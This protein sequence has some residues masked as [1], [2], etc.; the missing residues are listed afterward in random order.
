M[1]TN[2]KLSKDYIDIPTSYN[3]K[4]GV[5]FSYSFWLRRGTHTNEKIRNMIIFTKGAP[6]ISPV[7]KEPMKGYI[8]QHDGQQNS[9][10]N[11]IYKEFQ[12]ELKINDQN[13]DSKIQKI[14]NNRLVKCPLVRFGETNDSLRIELNTIKNPHLFI[15]VDS[16]IFSLLKSSKKLSKYNLISFSI[17]DNV[18]FGGIERGIRVDVYIDDAL[19]KTQSFEN[20]ALMTN[21]GPMNLFPSN[22]DTTGDV[23]EIDVDIADLTYFNFALNNKEVEDVYKKGFTEGV[24]KPNTKTFNSQS[25][26]HKIN[27]YNETRQI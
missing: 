23:S 25:K 14:K 2:D 13:R 17:K 18:D 12:T 27:L 16:E 21:D 15:D 24:C 6:L 26:Y 10:K 5:E 4:G 1:N 3:Q 11:E 19:V 22:R 20:N 8:Y 9:D 7:E